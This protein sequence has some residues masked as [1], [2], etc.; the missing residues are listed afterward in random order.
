MDII[1]ITLPD[2]HAGEERLIEEMLS[3][4]VALVHIRKPEWDEA[5]VARLIEAIDS[6]WHS[7]LVVHDH[8]ALAARY[9]LHG[10][11]LTGR[12]TEPPA[13]Y[14]GY[15]SCGC[16]SLS[17]LRRR[18]DTA[19]RLLL[20]PIFDSISKPGYRAAY[21]EQELAQARDEGLIDNKVC[22]LGGVRLAY[23]P[24]LQELGFG[25]AALLGEAWNNRRIRK[26]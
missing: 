5:Q 18:R 24:K 22:A 14:T 8:Y 6:K 15:T 20:S 19:D 4:G 2:R 10:I 26:K 9:G 12:H 21:T 11:H 13:G 17:E 3:A 25:A 23:L 1:V 7:R 16:H